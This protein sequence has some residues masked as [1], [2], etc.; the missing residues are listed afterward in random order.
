MQR[1][2]DSQKEGWDICPFFW[3]YIM[4]LYVP[5][6]SFFQCFTFLPWNAAVQLK[7]NDW[8]VTP[9]LPKLLNLCSWHIMPIKI[10]YE[11]NV[12]GNCTNEYAGY[13]W[14]IWVRTIWHTEY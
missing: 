8:K 13:H 1:Y 9:V 7:K 2:W 4:S 5:G 12:P 10:K 3:T 14:A 11:D 6:F